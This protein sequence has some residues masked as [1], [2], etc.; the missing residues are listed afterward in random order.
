MAER[1]LADVTESDS[2]DD[3]F[4]ESGSRKTPAS[5]VRKVSFN[6]YDAYDAGPFGSHLGEKPLKHTTSKTS[7]TMILQNV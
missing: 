3:E 1:V 4:Q 5:K 2:S 6:P 7:R